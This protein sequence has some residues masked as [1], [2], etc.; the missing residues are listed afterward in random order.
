MTGDG[1]PLLR[2]AV[3]AVAGLATLG[4]FAAMVVQRRLI[5]PFGRPARAI[6]RLT[7]PLLQPIERRLVRTGGNPQSAPWWLVGAALV[8]GIV[9]ISLVEWLIGQVGLVLTVAQF[10]PRGVAALLIN[11]TISLLMVALLVRVVGSWFG[12]S[13]HRPWMR[14][15]FVL[16]EWMLRPLRRVVPAFGPL[17]I[18]PIV[19]W[20]ALSLLRGLLL[21]VL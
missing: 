21:G 13:P 4:G 5:S 7:D 11:W 6:R 9:L 12:I 8:S 17:D 18:T 3:L 15:V 14:P 10:G 20:F 19:A 16:T 1:L 2:Y